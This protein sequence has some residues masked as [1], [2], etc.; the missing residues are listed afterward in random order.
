[1]TSLKIL[2]EHGLIHVT[3]RHAT[4]LFK[5]VLPYIGSVGTLIAHESCLLQWISSSQ[6]DSARAPNALKCPQCGCEYDIESERPVILRLLDIGNRTL[7]IVGRVITIGSATAVVVSIG[8][9]AH[10]SHR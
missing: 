8:A 9:G 2:L 10:R 3:V 5:P 1:M 4:P 6:A 7:S